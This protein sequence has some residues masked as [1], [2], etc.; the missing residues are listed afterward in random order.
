M[1]IETSV[2]SSLNVFTQPLAQKHFI[3]NKGIVNFLLKYVAYSR[4]I[5]SGL[6]SGSYSNKTKTCLLERSVK[7]T[8]SLKL[9]VVYMAKNFPVFCQ[10]EFLL[11][12]LSETLYFIPH[13]KISTQHILYSLIYQSVLRD[14]HKFLQSEFST[15]SY[16]MLLSVSC[17]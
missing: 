4:C 17:Y 3:K 16:Q 5:H 2:N 6:S 1:V 15:E 12:I 7:K 13:H 9:V 14:V 8:L 11:A 10:N